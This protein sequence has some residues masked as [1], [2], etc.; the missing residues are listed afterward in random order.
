MTLSS[1]STTSLEDVSVANNGGLCWYQLEIYKD[2]KLTKQLVKRAETAGYKALVVTVDIPVAGIKWADHRH[3]F[4]LANHLS[5]PH[6]SH[7]DDMVS[8]N[9][10]DPY[11][12]QLTARLVNP[13]T[14]WASIDWLRS[15]TILPI[16]LKGILRADDA[17][18]A[19][20]HDI[21]G[22]IVSNHGGRQL[23]TVP[24]TVCYLIYFHICHVLQI[25]T[26]VTMFP[27]YIVSVT[28]CFLF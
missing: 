22:I 4:I 6:F 17:R 2:V 15:I 3:K 26:N 12:E 7:A 5:L 16:V 14:T 9:S 13:K 19:L 28:P 8:N 24:A 27:L 18:E 23:D 20:K 11:F 1:W 25:C 10:D 21:Q